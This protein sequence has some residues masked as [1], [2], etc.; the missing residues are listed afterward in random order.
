M[1]VS[2]ISRFKGLRV[3]ALQKYEQNLCLEFT[4]ALNKMFSFR[5]LKHV[6]IGQAL[7]V[8]IS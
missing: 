4:G 2:G 5:I 1:F 7:Q 6:I 8:K 3:K